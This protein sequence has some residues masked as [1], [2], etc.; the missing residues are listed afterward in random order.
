MAIANEFEDCQKQ[1]APTNDEFERVAKL[2]SE[3]EQLA[4]K[5]T[6][7]N[8]GT[9]PEVRLSARTKN[10]QNEPTTTTR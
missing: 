4:R 9:K 5:M 1:P 8:V 6:K 2:N 3:C 10:E 7:H